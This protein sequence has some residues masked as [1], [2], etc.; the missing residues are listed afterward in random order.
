MKD[1]KTYLLKQTLGY[2]IEQC[3]CNY[4]FEF[5]MQSP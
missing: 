3:E 2:E 4:R 1:K 5:K